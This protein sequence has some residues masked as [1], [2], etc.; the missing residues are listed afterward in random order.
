MNGKFFLSYL[1][2]LPGV[3]NPSMVV[4]V[5]NP[6]EAFLRPVT[7][8]P[9]KLNKKDV[10]VLTQWRNRYVSSFL[11]QFEATENRTVHWLVDIVRN[12]DNKILFMLDD[13]NGVTLGYMGLDFINWPNKSGEL[14]AI[15]RGRNEKPGL[16]S[17]ALL[18]LIAWARTY[19]GL[20]HFEVRVRSDNR[21]IEF[22]RK[23]GFV[24]KKRIPL[25]HV[26]QENKI[27]FVEDEKLEVSPVSLVK[28]VYLPKNIDGVNG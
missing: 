8:E 19:L 12:N 25:R 14:D 15:V 21:A 2:T 28:M 23:L 20:N 4:P 9:T 10:R 22:Y 3:D 1:K 16:M 7:T 13:I 24:E 26:V 17:Q 5:G 11:T 18:T 6:V 27:S